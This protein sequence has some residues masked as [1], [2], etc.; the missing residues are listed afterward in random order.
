VNGYLGQNVSH[1]IQ[2]TVISF[3]TGTIV[4]LLLSIAMGIFPPKF[5]TSPGSLPWWAWCGGAIGVAMVTSSLFFV[6]RVGS[7]VWFAAIMTGQTFMA[8][9]LDHFGLLGNPRSPASPL[10]LTGAAL[11]IAGVLVIVQ[12][13]R[14]EEAPIAND[15]IGQADLEPME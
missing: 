9:L 4:V 8:I 1:P 7:L 11:L 5:T 13:R 12:A 3:V 2:A 10:R 6:P 14:S 15:R